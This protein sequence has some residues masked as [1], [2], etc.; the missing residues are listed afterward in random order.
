MARAW[1]GHGE[2]TATARREHGDSMATAWPEHGG[3]TATVLAARVDAG[4]GPL[5]V[6]L[7][8]ALRP[9]LHGEPS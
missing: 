9:D 2:S 6:S 8:E 3:R 4:L 1:R 7:V 5:V